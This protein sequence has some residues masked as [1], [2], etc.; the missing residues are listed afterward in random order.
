MVVSFSG[1]RVPGERVSLQADWRNLAARHYENF[2]VGSWL[3]GREARLH[4]RRIYAFARTA[5]DLADEEPGGEEGFR[6][7]EALKEDFL[8]ALEGR[9][10][11]PMLEALAETVRAKGLEVSLF[12]DLVSAFQQD[13]WKRRYETR[14]EVLDY[15]RRSADPVGRLVLRVH[16]VRSEEGDELSDQVCTGLQIANFLQDV[17]SDFEERDRIYLPREEWK[18]WDEGVLREG[19]ATEPF[20]ETLRAMTDW[21]RGMFRRGWKLTELLSGRLAWEVRAILRGGA[22]VLERVEAAGFDVLSR[23]ERLRL[24]GRV[25]AGHLVLGMLLSRPPASLRGGDSHG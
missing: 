15:C 22:A 23:P 1:A 9:P 2:P 4:L 21:T 12:L 6:A 16:G 10:A 13:T 8:G 17:R 18:G 25:R 3:L 11:H 5:D 24:P 7:L 20:R 14:E 19:R